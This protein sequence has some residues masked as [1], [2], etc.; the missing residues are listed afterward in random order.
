MLRGPTDAGWFRTCKL[1]PRPK[2]S[3]GGTMTETEQQV[4]PGSEVHLDEWVT[5][6]I[7]DEHGYIRAGKILEWMDVVG[8]LAA[9]RHCRRPVVT[10]SVDGMELQKPIRV[11]ERIA[12][13]ASVAFTS[14]RSIGVSVAMRHG[15]TDEVTPPTSVAGYMT[16]VALDEE[17]KAL[18]IPQ[19]QPETPAEVARFREGRIRTEFRKKMLSGQLPELDVATASRAE[20]PLFI[21][22][23]LKLLPRSFQLPFDRAAEGRRH[24]HLSYVHK[25]E[26][27]RSGNLNFHGT[28]YGGTLMRWIESCAQLSARSHLQGAAVRLV[29]LHGLTFIRPAQRHVFIHVRSAVAHTAQDTLTALVN[30]HAEDPTEGKQIETLRA[31]LTYVPVAIDGAAP[32]AIFALE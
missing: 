9:T 7:A 14:T 21:R 4:R 19:F 12:M 2:T 26:P 20:N 22:E 16:F 3:R 28:L 32:A 6:E 29:G 31:F 27:I 1:H 17:G 13:T 11:G 5:P 18:P 8:V 23:L 15:P 10:A 24:A 30:V 25:I